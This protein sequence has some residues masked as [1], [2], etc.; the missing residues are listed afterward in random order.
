MLLRHGP[1]SL[2]PPIG[3]GE[4]TTKSK[5]S[6]RVSVPAQI[7][8]Q[9][10]LGFGSEHENI[11]GKCTYSEEEKSLNVFKVRHVGNKTL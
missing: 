9:W 4:K 7:S 10:L 11:V 1:K 8:W 3:L 5:Q 2:F 6:K